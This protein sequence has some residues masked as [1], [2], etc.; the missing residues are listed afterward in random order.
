MLRIFKIV[1]IGALLLVDSGMA[2]ITA[3][4]EDGLQNLIPLGRVFD[5]LRKE[6]T[7]DETRGIVFDEEKRKTVHVYVTINFSRKWGTNAD[8]TT[9][10]DTKQSRRRWTASMDM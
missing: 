6:W 1:G 9:T 5:R 10:G 8:S 4:S 7:T 3:N 2:Q